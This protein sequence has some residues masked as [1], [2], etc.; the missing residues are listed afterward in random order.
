MVS[1]TANSYGL[2]R[3]AHN[4]AWRDILPLVN[5]DEEL[6]ID[7]HS[8]PVFQYPGLGHRAKE[9]AGFTKLIR[10][11]LTYPNPLGLVRYIYSGFWIPI[12]Y[13]GSILGL[14]MIGSTY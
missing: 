6:T 10:L 9:T 8:K 13:I 14:G 1:R 3:L 7:S 4:K 12:I 2:E 5:L 11:L